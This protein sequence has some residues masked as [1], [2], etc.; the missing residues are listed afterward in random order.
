MPPRP[1]LVANWKMNGLHADGIARASALAGHA[2]GGDCGGDI[3]VCPP[4]TLL[5]ALRAVFSGSPIELGGQ[6]CH[7]TPEGA[8]TGDVSAPMLADAG[9][10]YVIVGHSERRAGHGEADETVAGK[11]AAAHAAGLA[12]IVCVGESAVDRDDGRAL[13]VI[14]RQVECSLPAGATPDNTAIA[15]EPVW[16]IG[17]GRTPAPADI[18]AAHAEVRAGWERRFSGSGAAL[19]VLYGGS[20]TARNA[21]EIM[22]APGVDGV[23]V[24]GASLSADTF[25][26]ICQACR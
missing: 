12:A 2:A 11:A 5:F 6:D 19:R 8:H 24:G 14:G 21:G 23:L 25:W 7:A 10:A 20:V 9:C 17:T 22:A 26:Q 15:Y 4:A 13:A 18:E 1:L 3:V 16:A